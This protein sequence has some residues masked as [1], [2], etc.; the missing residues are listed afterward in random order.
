MPERK[1]PPRG[2]VVIESLPWVEFSKG[3]R[4]AARTR[5]L[6]DTRETTTRIGIGIEELP[7][8]KQSCPFHYHLLEEEHVIVL[9]GAMTLRLGDDE[10]PLKAGDYACFPAGRREAH[11]FVNTGSESCRYIII[12]DNNPNEVCI[13]PDSNKV[14]ISGFGRKIIADGEQRDYWDGERADEPLSKT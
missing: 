14:M 6:S 5:F 13:Y 3:V 7:P 11:C 1:E 9:E 8:G 12:G 2:P 10:L 4:Y